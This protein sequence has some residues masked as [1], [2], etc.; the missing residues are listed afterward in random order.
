MKTNFLKTLAAAA[1]MLGLASRNYAA[2]LIVEENGVSP[3]FATIQSAVTAA[4]AGD[5]IFVKNK[6][7]NVPYQENVTINKS[8]SILSYDPDAV[9]YVFGTY[10]INA[11]ANGEINI[12][13]MYNQSGSVNSFSAGSLTAPTRV[14]F[15]GSTLVAGNF[16]LN[17]A[18]FVAH[19]AG[20]TLLGGSIITK[21]ATITGNQVDGSISVT[22]VGGNVTGYSEDTLYIVG[23][24]I[25][26][27]AGGYAGGNIS[28]ANDDDYFLIANNWVRYNGAC[29]SVTSS[30]AGTG[31]NAIENNSTEST[32]GVSHGISISHN[33]AGIMRVVNNSLYDEYASNDGTEYAIFISGVGTGGV[34]NFDFNVYRNYYNGF[35]NISGATVSMTGNVAAG[36]SFNNADLTGVCTAPECINLGSPSTDYTD[37]DLSRNDVG[38]A[39]GSYNFNNFWP[40]N[41]GGARVYLVKTPRT[42]VQSS[43]INAKADSFDR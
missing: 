23:N 19:V 9:Y 13:G 2:D 22:D 20:N 41:T 32:S 26:T 3:N 31:V 34:V 42:V 25:C 38:V 1:L 10:T 27:T 12:I 4:T 7:G 16:N 36:T 14:N 15:M 33:V 24:R 43:T 37:L 30:K 28:W 39:G 29:I 21:T 40:N 35:T 6:A 5:R 11:I 17:H 8:I 18:G